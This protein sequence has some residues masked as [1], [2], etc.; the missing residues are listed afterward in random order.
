MS[1]K[2]Q[3]SDGTRVAAQKLADD[4]VAYALD[5]AAELGLR[6]WY[7]SVEVT[8][9]RKGYHAMVRPTEGRRVALIRI[10]PDFKSLPPKTQRN[11]IVHELL[12]LH[13]R[14]TADLIRI[15][16]GPR[17]MSQ[18]AYDVVWAQYKV[19]EELATDTLAS[20]IDRRFP[21]PPWT[22]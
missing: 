7:L 9:R 22:E 13:H 5:L 8:A 10:G 15:Q 17:V 21:L 4:V 11:A 14:D 2:V 19:L 18:I 12:H 20:A 6:D 16:V 3:S 1:K